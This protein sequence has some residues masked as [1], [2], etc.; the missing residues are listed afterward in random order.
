MVTISHLNVAFKKKIILNG[1]DLKV[2]KGEI[3][4]IT[5]VN[6]SGKTVL[7]KVLATLLRPTGGKVEIAGYDIVKDRNSARSIIGYMPDSVR[8]DDRLTVKEYLD[9]FKAMYG[10]YREG[11]GISSEELLEAI[12]L[13]KRDETF[14][15]DLSRGMRQRILLAR[16]IVHDP[17]LLLLDDPDIGMDSDG[18][19]K[20]HSLLRDLSGKGKT[21]IF[22]SHSISLL[23]RISNRIGVIHEG[24]LIWT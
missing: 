8:L 3:F 5:G 11:D 10:R 18:L 24:R 19:E 15:S 6:G 2:G 23:N 9:F 21:V 17:S 13:H 12:G 22:S 20:M 14:L 7:I 4:G 16:A 1:I